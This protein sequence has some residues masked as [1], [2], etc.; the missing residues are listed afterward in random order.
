MSYRWSLG[1]LKG[2]DCL[3]E[4]AFADVWLEPIGAGY[5]DRGTQH[6]GETN[7]QTTEGD[8]A[9]ALAGDEVGEEVDVGGGVASP[10]ATEPKRRRCATPAAWSSGACCRSVAR[11]WSL[12][13][14]AGMGVVAMGLSVSG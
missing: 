10:R 6:V 3:P 9:D 7:F 1:L 4:D 11:M 14:M 2:N 8:E 5:F 13:G 12:T